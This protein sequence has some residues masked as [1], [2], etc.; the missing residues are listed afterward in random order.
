[1]RDALIAESRCAPNAVSAWLNG[2][3]TNVTTR[4]LL[5]ATADRL[6]LPR[7]PRH[8]TCDECRAHARRERL[9][10]RRW[11]NYKLVIGDG[12]VGRGR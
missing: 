8:E 9:G 5:E 11:G 3:H 6:G 10:E 12:Q 7:P 1:M 4:A 2:Q